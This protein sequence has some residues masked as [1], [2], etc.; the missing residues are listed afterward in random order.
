MI[1]LENKTTIKEL[2]Q[3][4]FK[5]LGV[6]KNN[7]IHHATMK[8]KIRKECNQSVRAVLKTEINIDNRMKAINTLTIS[9]VT[10]SFKIFNWTAPDIMKVDT[11]I[12]TLVRSERVHHP[13]VD[14]DSLYVQ[15]CGC[16]SKISSVAGYCGSRSWKRRTHLL[17]RISKPPHQELLSK[18]IKKRVLALSI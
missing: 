8:E 3:D 17:N 2:K 18:N 13:R 15:R 1:K 14:I 5:Y 10:C 9:L 6:N 7:R 12:Q 11:K 16:S 4:V